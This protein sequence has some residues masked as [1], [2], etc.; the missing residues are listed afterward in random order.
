MEHFVKSKDIFPCS[1]KSIP[2]PLSQTVSTI[3]SLMIW[4]ILAVR[5][6]ELYF[7]ALLRRFRRILSKYTAEYSMAGIFKNH[8]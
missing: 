3:S 8:L 1:F 2:N 5:R 7:N 6:G 4:S